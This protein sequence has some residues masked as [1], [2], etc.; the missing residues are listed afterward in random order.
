MK[1]IY[2]IPGLGA[3]E[4]MFSKL[5]PEHA[6]IRPLILPRP[7]SDESLSSYASRLVA[8]ID[9]DR[10]FYLL[11]QSFGGI[12][13]IEMARM[14][15]PEMIILVSSVKCRAELPWYGRLIG[16]FRLHHLAPLSHPEYTAPISIFLNG[17]ESVEDRAVFK[18]FAASRD[19]ALLKWS[20]DQTL[21]WPGCA[22]PDNLVHIHGTAD[23]LLPA[24]YVSPHIWIEGGTHFM[25]VTRGA[26][27]SA[28]IDKLVT[29]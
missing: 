24:R 1:T 21:K 18:S 11:G 22:I 26:E 8:L 6:E 23:R 15:H 19:M 3:N 20:L 7:F 28:L 25:M 4:A 5:K 29:G 13:S 17:I 27:I 9:V 10:P 12:L 14:C 2:C 16:R